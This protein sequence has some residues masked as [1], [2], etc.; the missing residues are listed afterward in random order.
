MGDAVAE[1]GFEPNERNTQSLSDD[2]LTGK[3]A[4]Y[5]CEIGHFPTVNERKLKRRS[6]PTFP[7]HGVIDARFGRR[8]DLLGSLVAF[9]TDRPG[10]EVVLDACGPLLAAEVVNSANDPDGDSAPGYVY[11]IRM[12]KWH[13][14]GCTRDILRRQGELRIALPTKEHLVHTIETDDP[15]GVE[16]YWHRRFADRRVQ[17]E[18][19]ELTPRDV[20]AFRL[21]RKIY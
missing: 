17:G 12:D 4:D 13:N 1:A 3:I 11:L 7:S 14:I 20:K 19:F 6:D 16:G 5:V 2:E 9:A 15:F 10:Y 21:W 8:Q 18:W